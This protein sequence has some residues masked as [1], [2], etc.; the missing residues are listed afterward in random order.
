MKDRIGVN[1][2]SVFLTRFWFPFW[3]PEGLRM[4]VF[5]RKEKVASANFRE[6]INENGRQVVIFEN[7]CKMII[8][9]T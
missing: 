1:I 4:Q 9:E 2:T 8:V 5:W 3:F 6:K 7:I